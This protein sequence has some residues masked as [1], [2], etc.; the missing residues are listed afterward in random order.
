MIPMSE[1]SPPPRPRR[2]L[3]MLAAWSGTAALVLPAAVA[4]ATPASADVNIY[5]ARKEHLIKP[6]LDR[7]TASTG[8]KVN[9]VTADAG[10]LLERLRSEGRNS[11]ADILITVD[12]G[13]LHAAKEAGVLQSVSSPALES[14][15]PAAYRDPQGHWFGLSLRARPI[16]YVKGKLTPG[17]L[18]S[19]EDLAD[20]RWKGR[21]CIRSSNNI[22]NQSLVA[23]ILAA[24]GEA[25]TLAWLQGFVGNF[26]RKPSGGDRDQLKAAAAGECD[27]AIANTYYL[28][29]M[30][31]SKDA[32][33]REAASR[34]AVFWPNQ[35]GRG[36]H[37]NVSGAGVTAASKNKDDAIRLLE[38]L[39]TD[40]SQQW[41]ANVNNE[42]PV[43]EGVKLSETVA[44]F[45]AYKADDLNLS[46]L[47]LNN[48]PAVQLMDRAGWK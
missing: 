38:F 24:R 9:L 32:G 18:S 23:A 12:A 40:E 16:M 13:N 45:G 19:Y 47:G 11:P 17:E 34:I 10:P 46:R 48:H 44:G 27:I 8:V 22:Y 33:E 25:D 30:I 37:V 36:A 28:A 3:A 41:Y 5:S 39:V 6:L 7:F 4:L 21:I 42:Y 35:A 26:A 2:S 14:A 1:R 29:Q 31:A 15:V 20:P 43:R